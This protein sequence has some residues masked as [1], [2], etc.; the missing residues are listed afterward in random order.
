MEPATWPDGT[1]DKGPPRGQKRG[2]EEGGD[3]PGEKQR[4]ETPTEEGD[5]VSPPPQRFTAP[6]TPATRFLLAVPSHARLTPVRVTRLDGG[7]YALSFELL[8]QQPQQQLVVQQG[9][10]QRGWSPLDPRVDRV[11]LLDARGQVSKWST[12]C[13][14]AVVVAY[15]QLDVIAFTQAALSKFVKRRATL[16]TLLT[17]WTAWLGASGPQRVVVACRVGHE[18]SPAVMLLAHLALAKACGDGATWVAAEAADRHLAATLEPVRM[19]WDLG[20]LALMTDLE[21]ALT[22]AR[23]HVRPRP[24]LTFVCAACGQVTPAAHGWAHVSR[25]LLVC[26]ETACLLTLH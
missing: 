13:P 19:G 17:E 7:D 9:A 12:N 18:R 10:T 4:R 23:A 26:A 24:D 6:T 8:G 5:A 1:D 20:V 16:D 25:A 22:T 21:T 15:P 3:T 11:M 2:R 14:G